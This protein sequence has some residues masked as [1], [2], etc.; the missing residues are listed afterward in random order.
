MK[1]KEFHLQSRIAEPE[2]SGLLRGLKPV[3]LQSWGRLEVLGLFPANGSS[4]SA[5]RVASLENLKLVGVP[6]YGTMLLRNTSAS[7]SLVLPMHIGFFQKS[8]QNHATSRVLVLGAGETLGV[9]D[10]FCIQAA[11]GG[12]LEE[13]RPRFIM[14]PLNLRTRALETRYTDDYSRLWGSIEGYTRSY[15]I[16]R[17]GHLERFLR[18][19]FPRLVRYRHAFESLPGQVGAAYFVAGDLVG[20]ELAPSAEV[21]SELWPIL[22]IY[23]YG[24]AAVRAVQH[25]AQHRREPLDLEGLRDLDDLEERLRRTRRQ[26]LVA[27]VEPVRQLSQHDWEATTEEDRHGFSVFTLR[28]GSWR[29]QLVRG[30]TETAHLSLFRTWPLAEQKGVA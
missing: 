18:P 24:P 25:R 10:C 15:G 4:G 11:Q 7:G 17:G 29:G 5:G 3:G 23:C 14:L 22:A 2:F 30:G 21:W 26:E 9:S 27:R 13:A 8:A 20:V 1:I 6:S 19:Y 12:Y 16:A 28:C